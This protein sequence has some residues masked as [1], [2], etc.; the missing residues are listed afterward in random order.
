[1]VNF[2]R[3]HVEVVNSKICEFFFRVLWFL[4]VETLDKEYSI[5]YLEKKQIL[6]R[7]W[8]PNFTLFIDFFM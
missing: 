3:R 5:I 6:S 8:D 1:M 4:V 2:R 7:T